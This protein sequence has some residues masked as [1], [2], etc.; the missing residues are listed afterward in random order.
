MSSVVNVRTADDYLSSKFNVTN[1][2]QEQFDLGDANNDAL[3][4]VSHASY[5]IE[6][7]VENRRKKPNLTEEERRAIW[8]LLLTK[9]RPDD[10]NKLLPSA[11][12]EVGNQFG[13]SAITV[14]KLFQRGLDSL[15]NGAVVANVTANKKDRV[16][17]KKSIT[18]TAEQVMTIPLLKRQNIRSLAAQLN[19]SKSTAHRICKA[20]K[21]I[22]P[23]SNAIKP[24]L[25]SENKV[26][27]VR[28]CLSHLELKLLPPISSA[29]GQS[30]FESMMDEASGTQPDAI[31]CPGDIAQNAKDFICSHLQS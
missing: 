30:H 23:H 8:E 20:N 31:S 9:R 1:V 27:R 21:L 13:V 22:K 12:P 25:T 29:A 19:I 3:G 11:A 10:S 4:Q 15:N 5:G 28:Y 2:K 18:V 16:G 7:S 6:S 14:R 17:R 26:Q 24:F